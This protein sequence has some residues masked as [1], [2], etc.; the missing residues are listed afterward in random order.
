MTI[1]IPDPLEMNTLNLIKYI[2]AWPEVLSAD[3]K[4]WYEDGSTTARLTVKFKD[5]SDW[6]SSPQRTGGDWRN[7]P[8]TQTS[9]AKIS[10]MVFRRHMTGSAF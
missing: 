10:C 8:A 5:G 1:S 4:C 7:D 3:W 9:F 2:E 6:F